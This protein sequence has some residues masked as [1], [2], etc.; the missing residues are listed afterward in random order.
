M[1]PRR[2]SSTGPSATTATRRSVRAPASSWGAAA[3]TYAVVSA[4]SPAAWSSWVRSESFSERSCSTWPVSVSPIVSLRGPA[5]SAM[6]TASARNT[7]MSE[8]MWYLK[9]ITVRGLR[10]GWRSS[11][12][13][14]GACGGG[15][16]EDSRRGPEQLAHPRRHVV[17]SRAQEPEQRLAR[18]GRRQGDTE[19]EEPGEHEQDELQ[20]R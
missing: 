17:D 2:S 7:E 4:R 5:P 20:V 3:S 6:P 14:T 11:A 10:R 19:R 16:R 13:R 12:P 18:G 9:S 15:R 8:T 1:A